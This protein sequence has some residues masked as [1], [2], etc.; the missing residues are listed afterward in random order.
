MRHDASPHADGWLVRQ[1]NLHSKDR[2]HLRPAQRIVEAASQYHCEIRVTKDH[3]DINA[4][5]IVDMIEFTAYMVNRASDDDLGF[6]FLAHGS[7]AT[8]ALNALDALVNEN[9]WLD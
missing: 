1:I 6:E 9:F 4:K 7:D 5:S 2:L 3:M 8:E